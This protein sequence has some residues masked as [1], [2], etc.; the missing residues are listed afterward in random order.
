[1]PR[2]AMELPITYCRDNA[3]VQA[4][5]AERVRDFNPYRVPETARDVLQA[6]R[7]QFGD[8]NCFWLEIQ[9]H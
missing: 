2:S 3:A 1:M 6:A 7:V 9:P 8:L 4:F 5:V